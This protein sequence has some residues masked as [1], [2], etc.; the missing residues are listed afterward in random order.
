M[1]LSMLATTVPTGIPVPTMPM[2]AKRPMGLETVTDVPFRVVLPPDRLTALFADQERTSGV[3]VPPIL[4][5][6]RPS[7]VLLPK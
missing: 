3:V 6:T 5:R 1:P 4:F 7:C 2:P